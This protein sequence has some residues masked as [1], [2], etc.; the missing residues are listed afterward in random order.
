MIVLIDADVLVDVALDRSPFATQAISLLDELERRPGGC[1][2]AWHSLSNFYYL[3][4][5][6]RGKA[7]AREFLLDLCRF[8]DVA[9]TTTRSLRFAASLALA[10]FEDALQVAAAAAC[11]ADVIATRNTR[12]YAKSPIRAAKPEDVVKELRSGR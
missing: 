1:Y 12:D 3:V 2:V 8:C 5:P 11:G 4:A 10:D 9:P 6:L 7:S